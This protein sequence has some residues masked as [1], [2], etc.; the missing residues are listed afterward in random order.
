MDPVSLGLAALQFL[1][2]NGPTIVAMVEGKET[3]SEGA[4]EILGLTQTIHAV[5]ANPSA[6]DAE[7][8]FNDAAG[9]LEALL[10]AA[11]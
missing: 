1:I 3:V 6:P 10:Q 5:A 11:G 8:T 2:K 9:K 4:E 7:A